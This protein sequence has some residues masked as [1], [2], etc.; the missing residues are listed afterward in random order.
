MKPYHS[1]FLM[2][3]IPPVDPLDPDLPRWRQVYQRIVGCINW[4][5]TF[6]RP[7]ISPIITLLASYRN[8]PHP[9]HYKAALHA[10]KYL[11]STNEYSISFHSGPHT[12]SKHSTNFHITRIERPKQ[13]Q[14][15]LIFQNATNSR[16]TATQTGVVNLV[17]QS[18]TALHS[19]F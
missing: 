14:H 11:T 4:L 13:R 7:D 6:N 2:D 16:P 1:S 5:A 17:S 9:Q 12:Q 15:I 10:I 3:S 18:K 8:S 19:I